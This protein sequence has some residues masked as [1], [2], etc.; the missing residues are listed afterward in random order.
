MLLEALC[1]D[2]LEASVIKRTSQKQSEIYGEIYTYEHVGK[3]QHVS[4]ERKYPN[5]GRT[6]FRSLGKTTVPKLNK[7]IYL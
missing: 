4:G 3:I 7:F 6:G 2:F 5:R 1:C